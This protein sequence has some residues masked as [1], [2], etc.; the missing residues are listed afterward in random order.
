MKSIV[1]LLALFLFAQISCKALLRKDDHHLESTAQDHHT[2]V[3]HPASHSK[4]Q[5]E[6]KV[7]TEVKKRKNV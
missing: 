1:L 2:E 6:N 7:A 4:I 5:T 3:A